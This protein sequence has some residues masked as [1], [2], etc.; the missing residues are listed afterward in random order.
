[1]AILIIYVIFLTSCGK[2]KEIIKPTN[3][4]NGIKSFSFD[5]MYPSPAVDIDSATKTIY[6]LI[7][8]GVDPTNLTPKIELQS[9]KSYVS[10]A[11]GKANNFLSSTAYV[12]TAEDG[13]KTTYNV[14]IRKPEVSKKDVPTPPKYLCIYYDCPSKVN[15]SNGNLTNAYNVFKNFDLIVFADVLKDKSHFDHEN[16]KRLISMLKAN[17]PN[18]KIFGYIDL[19]V[20]NANWVHNFSEAQLEQFIDEWKDEMGANG[21]FADDFGYDFGV[22]RSRQNFF[23]DYA[24]SR[25]LSVFANGWNIDDVLG[26]EDCHLNGKYSDYYLIESFLVSRGKFTSLTENVNKAKKAYFYMKKYDVGIAVT[27]TSKILNSSTN[28]TEEYKM[29]WH[30]TSMFN[31]DAFQFTDEIYSANNCTNPKLYF[32]QNPTSS[33]GTSWIDFDWVRKISE[34]RYE[35]STNSS[36]FYIEGNGTNLGTGGH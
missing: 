15:G 1:M 34:T 31:F 26:G 24:H 10:P 16:T 5:T 14:I 19:G 28:M 9:K 21:V 3:S 22:T 35:R 2:I 7:P 13:S 11:S 30:A 20:S 4:H 33:Y 8:A 29:A 23:I 36:T 17:N 18:L 32:Y 25:G 27:S 12:V 6:I